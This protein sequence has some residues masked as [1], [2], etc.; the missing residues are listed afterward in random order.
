MSFFINFTF[1]HDF[2]ILFYNFLKACPKAS[3]SPSSS[4]TVTHYNRATSPSLLGFANFNQPSRIPSESK[5]DP[6]SPPS[7]TSDRVGA[8]VT[9]SYIRPDRFTPTSSGRQG[10]IYDSSASSTFYGENVPTP[11]SSSFNIKVSSRDEGLQYN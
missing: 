3:S 11:L 6:L 2:I 4:L 10:Q 1:F 5:L 7:Q 8:R 9:N